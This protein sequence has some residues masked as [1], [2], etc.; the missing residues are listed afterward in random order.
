MKKRL[1]GA[2]FAIV[3][4]VRVLCV[5]LLVT[6][7]T[8]MSQS[9]VGVRVDFVRCGL[10]AP[11]LPIELDANVLGLHVVG[12]NPVNHRIM[13]LHVGSV[14]RGTLAASTTIRFRATAALEVFL[15]G[16]WLRCDQ[17]SD[18]SKVFICQAM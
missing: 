11:F 16:Q 4:G 18:Q 1:E 2:F 15:V 5:G 10:G 3:D 8:D 12:R 17:E 14:V 6:P 7:R 13:R 9:D